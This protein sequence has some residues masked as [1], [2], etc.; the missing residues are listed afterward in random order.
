MKVRSEQKVLGAQRLLDL[1]SL[2]TDETPAVCHSPSSL[3]T[4]RKGEIKV[5]DSLKQENHL[6]GLQFSSLGEVEHFDSRVLQESKE[7]NLSPLVSREPLPP[8]SGGLEP[9]VDLK[10]FSSSAFSLQTRLK[11]NFAFRASL[12]H[13]LLRRNSKIAV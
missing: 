5:T 13:S 7:S 11:C 4:L 2:Q 12:F 8:A 6:Q 10:H 9:Q 3:Q 1:E